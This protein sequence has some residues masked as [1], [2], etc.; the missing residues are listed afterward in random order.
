MLARQLGLTRTYNLFNN[1][2]CEDEDIRRLRELHATMDNAVLACYNWEDLDL[3]HGF[4]QNDRGQ[5][6]YTVS[7][8]ARRELLRRLLALNLELAEAERPAAG[9]DG[10]PAAARAGGKTSE[11][12]KTA[13]AAPSPARSTGAAG[14]S[15]ARRPVNSA[16][17]ELPVMLDEAAP[18]VENPMEQP[19]LPTVTDAQPE[20]P[21]PG[22]SNYSLYRCSLCDKRVFGFDRQNHIREVHNGKKVD[23]SKI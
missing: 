13:Q 8:A 19:P 16:Q 15:A 9:K 5:V 12:R 14:R 4:H 23:F 7:P 17:P 20:E 11:G 22:E 3:G 6:R 21:Q 10:K 2:A 18:A 1:P